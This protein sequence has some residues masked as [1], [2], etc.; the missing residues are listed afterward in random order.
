MSEPT[1]LKTTPKRSTP[2]RATRG[3]RMTAGIIA[4][5]SLTVLAAA[6]WLNADPEGHGTHTQLGLSACGWAEY[7]EAPCAT[8]GMTTSFALA[9]DSN[10]AASFVT[11]P[12]G[13]LLVL[14]TSISFWGGLHTSATG[15][16]LGSVVA[17]ALTTRV[18]I[19]AAVLFL[20]AWAYKWAMW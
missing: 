8:C 7:F 4:L 11:Q 3:E 17:P 14:L 15:S 2:R 19:V 5:G 18:L 13:A 16:R 20:A 10:W 9:A 12:F 6:A 1:P